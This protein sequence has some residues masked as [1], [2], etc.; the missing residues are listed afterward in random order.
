MI[1][2][3]YLPI[4]DMHVEGA[5][6]IILGLIV[7]FISGFFGVGGGIIAVPMLFIIFNIPFPVAIGSSLAL[8]I[9]TSISASYRHHQHG[10]IDFKMGFVFMTGTVLGVEAGAWVIQGLKKIHEISIAG[11]TISATDLII[12]II[13]ILLLSTVGM[14]IF[15]ESRNAKRK[16]R[17]IRESVILKNFLV[18]WFRGFSLKP[19]IRF[20]SA[21]KYVSFWTVLWLSI[22]VGAIQGMLGVGGGF[23]LVP[24]MIY[25]LKVPTKI[26]I[27][28][29]L[30]SIILGSLYATFTHT[31]KGNVDIVLVTILLV[32]SAVG[33]QFGAAATR[34]FQG[35]SI[36]F[37][38][39]ILTFFAAVMAAIK[40]IIIVF[41]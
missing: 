19:Q 2:D 27:G 40:L 41:M 21:G 28:T 20:A 38:F 36:R 5:A 31:I 3:V 24:V 11:K 1:F 6:L 12:S 17:S 9:G 10:N 8:I 34:K 30:F 23:I 18:E 33:A 4:T 35:P 32:G 14:L 37:S 29:S 39:S 16:T 13:Y 15:R 7:G 25:L 22:F 26:A